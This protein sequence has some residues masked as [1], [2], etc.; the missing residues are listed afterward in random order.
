VR[1]GKVLAVGGRG[2]WGGLV[3]LGARSH[4]GYR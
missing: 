4:H 1:L 3:S 2:V